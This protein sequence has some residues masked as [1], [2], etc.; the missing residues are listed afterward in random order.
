MKGRLSIQYGIGVLIMVE[1]RGD[2]YMVV[3]TVHVLHGIPK[4]L[5]LCPSDQEVRIKARSF[6]IFRFRLSSSTVFDFEGI[7]SAL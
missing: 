4:Q 6:G 1:C 7:F 2:W 3:Q 5:L